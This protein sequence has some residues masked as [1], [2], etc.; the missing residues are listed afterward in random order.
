MKWFRWI[1][2]HKLISIAA[3][4]IIIG[5]GVLAGSYYNKN[6]HTQIALEA[7]GVQSI[8]NEFFAVRDEQLLKQDSA[9]MVVTLVDNGSAVAKGDT[10]ALLFNDPADARAYAEAAEN[11]NE[12]DVYKEFENLN[13]SGVPDLE[14]LEKE[15]DE[16]YTLYLDRVSAEDYAAASMQLSQLRSKLAAKE[17]AVGG[18]IVF[19]ANIK[20]LENALASFKEN[21]APHK[22]LTVESSGYFIG[23]TDGFE[24]SIAYADAQAV[25]PEAVLSVMRSQAHNR[26]GNVYGRLVKE[27]KW[28]VLVCLDNRQAAQLTIGKTYSSILENSDDELPMRLIALNKGEKGEYAAVFQCSVMNKKVSGFRKG[29]IEIIVTRKTGLKVNTDA[30]R[31][32][33]NAKTGKNETGVYINKNGVV[34]FRRIDIVFWGDGY[35]IAGLTGANELKMYDQ[36]IVSGRRLKEGDIIG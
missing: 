15:I 33:R 22:T 35:V 21:E 20:R 10:V 26:A 29:D 9:S 31:T 19:S 16:I 34:R 4:L 12:L 24:D 30:V 32:V 11:Q 3:A 25:R 17:I 14:K 28:Y 8:K 13:F 18:Q 2:E 5:S 36:V 27:Y 6:I 23:G 1:A 7:G